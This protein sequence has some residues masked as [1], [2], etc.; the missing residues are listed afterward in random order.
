MADLF[1]LPSTTLLKRVA[2][3]GQYDESKHP[4]DERG[5]WTAGGVARAAIGG[6]VA[7]GAGLAALA[8]AGHPAGRK[9]IPGLRRF[10]L[11]Q[12]Y[13]SASAAAKDPLRYVF[14]GQNLSQRTAL[15]GLG[16]FGAV[17]A[18][19]REQASTN[20]IRAMT[21]QISPAG[22]RRRVAAAGGVARPKQPGVVRPKR[23]R[24]DAA[25]DRW[26][27]GVNRVFNPFS[28]RP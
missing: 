23:T 9:L 11:G 22:V 24:T 10:V 17:S 12:R 18:R 14:R 27:L 2:K 7:G 21:G 16:A 20:A 1:E 28:G 15:G 4:R 6:A 8:A 25:L 3:A 26:V 19:G 13:R 5:R